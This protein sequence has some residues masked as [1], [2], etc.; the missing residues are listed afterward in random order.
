VERVG[1]GTSRAA[2]LLGDGRDLHPER[3]LH[4]RVAEDVPPRREPAFGGQ[5]VAHPG[6]AGDG[7]EPVER[8]GAH[9]HVESGG[10]QVGILDACVDDTGLRPLVGDATREGRTRLDGSDVRTYGHER[11]RGLS[12]SRS[13]IEDPGPSIPSSRRRAYRAAG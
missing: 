8:R 11:P 13:D 12:G 7:V 3:R 1:V 2:A 5:G 10:S 4:G 9:G 6:Q